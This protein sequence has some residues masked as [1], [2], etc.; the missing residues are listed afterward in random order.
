MAQ[1]SI[2]AARRPAPSR[3]AAPGAARLTWRV[4][5]LGACLGRATCMLAAVMAAPATAAS[6]NV[7]IS[8]LGDVAFGT[9]VDFGADA[10]SSQ[11]VC[12]FAHTDTGGYRIT[13]SGS[14]SDGSFVLGSGPNLLDY[15]VQWSQ[16]PGQS[17]GTQLSP[18]VTLTGMVSSAT[19][20]SCNNGPASSA[21]LI[22][23]LRSPALSN[24][25]AGSY[26]GTLTLLVGPE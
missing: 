8:N 6:N 7:R 25:A 16:S 4:V 15:E 17:S 3:A 2:A 5:R 14:S 1:A 20:Q 13:A 22:V 19:Q 12:V 24:A 21:S 9:L 11:S 26:S 18:N 23:I 10:V